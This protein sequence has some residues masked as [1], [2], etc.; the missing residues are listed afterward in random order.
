M[1]V[2][3]FDIELFK[4]KEE[5]SSEQN[6]TQI[7]CLC[8]YRVGTCSA[9]DHYEEFRIGADKLLYASQNQF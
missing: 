4:R 6:G 3:L 1:R 9:E 5:Y 2:G 8:Y 7:S